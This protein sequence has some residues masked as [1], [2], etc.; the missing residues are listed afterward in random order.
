M[1][2]MCPMDG[3]KAKSGLCIHDKM[4]I[5]MGVMGVMAMVA[6]WGVHLF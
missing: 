1:A 4:M 2:K 6:H 5:V 3:C